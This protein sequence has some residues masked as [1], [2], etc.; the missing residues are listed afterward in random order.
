MLFGILTSN[1]ITS[2]YKK[3]I[4]IRLAGEQRLGVRNRTLPSVAT[5]KSA[6]LNNQPH[7]R[8]KLEQQGG[9]WDADR[10]GQ[11]ITETD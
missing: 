3:K 5:L 2:Q 11:N 4:G 1:H 6:E 9:N 8:L 7:L 10:G